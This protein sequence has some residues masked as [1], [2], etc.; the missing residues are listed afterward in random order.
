MVTGTRTNQPRVSGWF[1]G[2]GV[3]YRDTEQENRE[4]EPVAGHAVILCGS[5]RG[6]RVGLLVPVLCV[7]HVVEDTSQGG[8]SSRD[9]RSRVVMLRGL[10]GFVDVVWVGGCC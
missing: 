9:N 2:W 6:S 4:C 10:C 8:G 5:C 3:W 7:W 1:G